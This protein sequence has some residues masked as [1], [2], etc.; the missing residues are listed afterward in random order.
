MA[1]VNQ[2]ICDRCGNKVEDNPEGARQRLVR[3]DSDYHG[4]K[5]DLCRACSTQFKTW[6]NGAMGPPIG[7]KFQARPCPHQVPCADPDGCSGQELVPV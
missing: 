2:T 4:T 6:L 1:K 7:Y 3:F 5:I